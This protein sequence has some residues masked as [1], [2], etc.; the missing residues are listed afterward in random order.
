M[1]IAYFDIAL[2]NWLHGHLIPGSVP[3][4]QMVSDTTTWVS[5]GMALL[6]GV[7]A[8]SKRSKLLLKQFIILVV[9]LLLVAATSQ[10]LKA[11]I[12]RDRPFYTH[13]GIEKLSSGGDA[14]FP[15]GHTLEAFA[16]A[17]AMSLI[18]RRK[19]IA[20]PLFLWALLVAYSRVAL[21]VH[22]P[23]DVLAG[24]VIGAAIGWL[25]PWTF[26]R[27]PFRILE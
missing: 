21:G 16:M 2:L 18:F 10:G 22:Y 14:S 19:L 5:I 20:I 15:S 8:L 6:V 12:D 9:V 3:A 24:M 4:L 25:V 11:L 17:A 26:R 13:P 1:N 27:M 23:S 7:L